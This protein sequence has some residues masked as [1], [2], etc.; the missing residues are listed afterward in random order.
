MDG[1]QK[2]K[3]KKKD[4]NSADDGNMEQQSAPNR[5][6]AAKSKAKSKAAGKAKAKSSGASAASGKKTIKVHDKKSAKSATSPNRSRK[7]KKS[8]KEKK[9]QQLQDPGAEAEL[10]D[11]VETPD[12]EMYHQPGEVTRKRRTP[13]S[14]VLD[15]VGLTGLRTPRQ[16]CTDQAP[17]NNAGSNPDVLS[18]TAPSGGQDSQDTE[19]SFGC[20]KMKPNSLQCT[21]V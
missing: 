12:T 15:A 11:E 20:N 9:S 10:P 19:W 8:K 18:P 6:T 7:P 4:V 2:P 16:K 13:V 14:T 17:S 21:Y 3:R 5:P 1:D